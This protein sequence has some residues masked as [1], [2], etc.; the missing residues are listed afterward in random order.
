[1]IVTLA[2][3]YV[4]LL[5]IPTVGLCQAQNEAYINRSDGFT[6]QQ[7]F[8]QQAP[9]V[10]MRRIAGASADYQLGAGDVIGVQ[11]LDAPHLSEKVE[12]QSDGN[13][14]LSLL[15]DVKAEGLTALQLETEIGAR[16][17]AASLVRSPEVLVY[18]AEYHGKPYYLFGEID[19]TGQY[20][21]SH[22]L[23]L[24]DAILLGGG[25]KGLAGDFGYLHRR[26]VDSR[27]AIAPTR[28]LLLSSPDVP[29]TSDG[30][31][32][33][34]DLRPLKSG[35]ILDVGYVLEEGDAFI[36]PRRQVRE[37]YV[38]GEVTGP[39]G[40][41][42]PDNEVIYATQAIA[43]AGGPMKTAK[44]KQGYL[45]RVD[46][47]GKRTEIAVNFQALLRG[48]VPDFT[49][50]ANDVLF[51]PGSGTKSLS[52]GLLGMLPNRVTQS[53]QQAMR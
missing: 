16:Y 12:V 22:R 2:R 11:V 24:T 9:L 43:Q 8:L 42:L 19:L 35:A 47:Q 40:F 48:E 6:D 33:K 1:M 53:A 4:L 36:V 32:I 50:Q 30:D 34:V 37:F 14:R 21:M 49:V 10:A 41:E 5:A 44:A 28:E 20:I 39:G 13:I 52:Y 51:I 27:T 45:V 29:L 25:L 46:E 18:I 31:V 38:V 7:Q 3:T 26:A 23:T 17:S 15:G